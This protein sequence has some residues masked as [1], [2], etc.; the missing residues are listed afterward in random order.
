MEPQPSY[1]VLG[2]PR[3][4][5]ADEGGQSRSISLQRWVTRGHSGLK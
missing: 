3:F 5:L 4:D 1:A 2:T